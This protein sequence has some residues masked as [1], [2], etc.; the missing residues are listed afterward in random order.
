MSIYFPEE[1]R[2]SYGTLAEHRASRKTAI[3][4]EAHGRTLSIWPLWKQANA[5]LGLYDQ[6]KAGRCRDYLAR[7][8]DYV[9]TLDA[10]IDAAPNHDAIEA[11]E[12]RSDDYE[13]P[14]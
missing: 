2:W 5:A 3:R 8:Q 11:V 6:D 9:D 1:D 14:T 12:F 13:T 10:Q 4:T 7:V